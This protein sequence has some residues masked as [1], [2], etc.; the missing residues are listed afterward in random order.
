MD[1]DDCEDLPSEVSGNLTENLEG[2]YGPLG[3]NRSYDEGKRDAVTDVRNALY[4]RQ[5]SGDS[6]PIVDLLS[7]T[8]PAK[9]SYWTEVAQELHYQKE[10]YEALYAWDHA[11]E[12]KP[13]ESSEFSF[14]EM[15]WAL[16]NASDFGAA[17]T[18]LA[19][20]AAQAFAINEVWVAVAA[21]NQALGK[22]KEVIIG[23]IETALRTSG[24]FELDDCWH[25]DG[26]I[27]G[28]AFNEPW[29]WEDL[30]YAYKFLNNLP[31]AFESWAMVARED[32][33]KA[34][35]SAIESLI[36]EARDRG[37]SDED[38]IPPPIN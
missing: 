37:Y 24:T 1:I 20:C 33:N 4:R 22:P 18:Y 8:A 12:F 10:H 3:T 17:D 6:T 19:E 29:T 25:I 15:G 36:Y 38:V 28:L 5:L 32:E 2:D 35:T 13:D 31:K 27:G 7:L 9:Q 23:I 11:A 26:G 21:I 30:A 16:W 34:I 14:E